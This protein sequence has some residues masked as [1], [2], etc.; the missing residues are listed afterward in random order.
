M[1][2][3]AL[4]QPE[5]AGNVGSI[6]RS[7]ACFDCELH[8]IEP[9]GFPFDLQRIKKS[10]MDYFEKARI[11]RYHSFAGFVA[12]Q[13]PQKL[14][15]FE[16][17]TEQNHNSSDQ[18]EIISTKPAKRLILATTKGSK[19]ALEF[20]FQ[21]D[22]LVIFGQESSGVPKEVAEICDEKIFIAMQNQARS[23][24]LAVSCGIVMALAQKR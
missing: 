2:R 3:I 18:A 8:I 1:I 12:K 7:C 6:I 10:A 24:N 21:S 15:S 4:F 16:A 17:K 9:C 11:V 14:K 22:D 19:D 5:I 23:L 13:F 20:Q